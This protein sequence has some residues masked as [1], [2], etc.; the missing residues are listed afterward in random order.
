LIR[1]ILF[2][3]EKLPPRSNVALNQIVV[4]GYDSALVEHHGVLCIEAGFVAPCNVSTKL[5]VSRMVKGLTWEGYEFLDNARDE[6]RWK[7]TKAVTTTVGTL[8]FEA[9]KMT[10][11]ELVKHTISNVLKGGPPSLPV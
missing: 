4:E 6:E 9:V 7:R 5:I 2:E 1:A 3:I 8:S 10:L 11:S